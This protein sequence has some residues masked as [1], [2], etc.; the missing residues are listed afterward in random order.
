MVEVG[1][2]LWTSPCPTHLIRV[3][4]SRMLRTTSRQPS[5]ISRDGAVSGKEVVVLACERKEQ[6]VGKLIQSK[7]ALNVPIAL[8]FFFPTFYMPA[9][10]F[11]L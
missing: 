5:N 9:C 3:T 6:K 11:L 2:G 7:C 1:R 4:Y 8:L 10:L